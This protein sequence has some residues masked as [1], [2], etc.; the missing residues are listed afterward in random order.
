MFPIGQKFAVLARTGLQFGI[1]QSASG[2]T[3]NQENQSASISTLPYKQ[4]GV[5]RIE[6]GIGAIYRVNDRFSILVYPQGNVALQSA[7][8]KSAFIEQRDFGL[9]THLG[10]KIDL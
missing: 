10:I 4:S 6:L 8:K 7:Y 9:Y 5:N 2:L 3:I 1:N